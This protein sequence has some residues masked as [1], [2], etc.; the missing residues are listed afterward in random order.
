MHN[1]T[2]RAESHSKVMNLKMLELSLIPKLDLCFLIN[3]IK[4][5]ALIN[6][7]SM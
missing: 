1:I 7:P 4:S 2:K 5:F 3:P 6:R